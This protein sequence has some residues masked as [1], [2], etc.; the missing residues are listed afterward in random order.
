MI[1]AQTQTQMMDITTLVEYWFL[2]S[3]HTYM[4]NGK[5]LALSTYLRKGKMLA[6]PTYLRKSKMLAVS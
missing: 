6:Y 4:E 1:V 5:M 3:Q 2:S